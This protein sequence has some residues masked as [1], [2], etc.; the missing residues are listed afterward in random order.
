MKQLNKQSRIIQPQHLRV[1]IK[2]PLVEIFENAVWNLAR[3]GNRAALRKGLQDYAEI[4]TRE[5]S[6]K[7]FLPDHGG[8]R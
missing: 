1:V 4:W 7:K 6:H 5:V 3:T 2:P 8:E